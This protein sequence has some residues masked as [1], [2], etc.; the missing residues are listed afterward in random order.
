MNNNNKKTTTYKKYSSKMQQQWKKIEIAAKWSRIHK[1]EEK[2][3]G[4]EKQRI[5]KI[6]TFN[7]N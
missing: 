7:N 3:N 2:I 4:N 5:I 1:N 6:K